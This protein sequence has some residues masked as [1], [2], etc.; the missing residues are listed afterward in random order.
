MKKNFFKIIGLITIVAFLSLSCG[1]GGNSNGGDPLGGLTS[2]IDDALFGTWKDSA[3]G[4]SLT[5]TFSETGII[6][7]GA[8]GDSLNTA[9]NAY[10]GSGYDLVWIADNGTISYKYSDPSGN[11]NTIP[12]YTYTFNSSGGLEL[13][14]VDQSG[15]GSVTM[16]EDGSSAG[17]TL[18]NDIAAELFGT[19][20]DKADETSLTITFSGTGITWGGTVGDSLNTAV[21][22]YQG[23]GYTFVWIANNGTI[24]YKYSDSS[25]NINT[26]PVY[27]YTF[28]SGELELRTAGVPG[29]IFATLV[30]EAIS[31]GNT[32]TI[33]FDATD[34]TGGPASVTA[35]YGSPMPAIT[36][37]P[38]GTVGYSF[39]GYFDAQTGGTMYYSASLASVKDWDKTSNTTLYAQWANTYT[40]TFNATDGTGGPAS[41]TATYGSPMP[42]I[43]PAP[44]GTG[45]YS[46]VGYFD[47]QTGGT[48]YYNADLT[49][50][51]TWDKEEDTTLYAQWTNT[52]TITFDA[53]EGS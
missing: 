21:N 13:S 12:V 22:A 34:G 8:A 26:I 48:I 16:V 51:K 14:A 18:T 53:N 2:D 43:T 1:G 20:K 36:P 33:T 40:I 5:I 23:T 7:G 29:Y 6:W 38:T 49:S 24:S 19:W 4:T 35:T 27:T 32:Y 37:A 47:A 11:V 44:T 50:A 39:V 9:V 42:A 3:D 17:G 45:G 25:G 30:N 28:N 31:G 10:Q 41:V 52:Y 15:L 46:F